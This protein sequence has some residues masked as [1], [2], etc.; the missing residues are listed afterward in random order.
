MAAR[1]I[2]DSTYAYDGKRKWFSL[3]VIL[4]FKLSE[5]LNGLACMVWWL[6]L[7][8]MEM[9]ERMR[10]DANGCEGQ[11]TQIGFESLFSCL[12]PGGWGMDHRCLLVRI[13]SKIVIG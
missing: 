3:E 6:S 7:L 1:H 10:M 4:V 11:T 13:V 12:S 9:R 8:V 5:R 2:R